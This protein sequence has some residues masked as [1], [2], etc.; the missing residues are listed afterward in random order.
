M[1]TQILFFANFIFSL[2]IHNTSK[3]CTIFFVNKYNLLPEYFLPRI[4][5]KHVRNFIKLFQSIIFLLSFNEQRKKKE[6]KK[7]YFRVIHAFYKKTRIIS[8]RPLQP[9]ERYDTSRGVKIIPVKNGDLFL[10]FYRHQVTACN[11]RLIGQIRAT[12][13]Q[14]VKRFVTPRF[15]KCILPF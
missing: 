2:V 12:H 5:H 7:K 8:F 3:F 11:I 4:I 15:R 6:K 9:R 10:P 1:F 14:R 13:G